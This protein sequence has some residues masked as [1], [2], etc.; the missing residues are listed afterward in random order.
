MDEDYFGSAAESGDEAD[1]GQV[2]RGIGRSP[3]R[4][5]RLRRRRAGSA[6]GK[7]ARREAAG[8]RGVPPRPR[9]LGVFASSPA[10]PW[11][12]DQAA[13]ALERGSPKLPVTPHSG[14]AR[15]RP[16]DPHGGRD[17]N[18]KV[19]GN[20]GCSGHPL[21]NM[22]SFGAVVSNNKTGDVFLELKEGM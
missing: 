17:T 18:T 11:G 13:V 14:Q 3:A 22:N 4:I 19:E 9:Q 10:G 20:E 15:R 2:R 6:P 1:G 7:P 8:V 16:C 21:M 12:G 5:V